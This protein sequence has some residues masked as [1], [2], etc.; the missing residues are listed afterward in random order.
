MSTEKRADATYTETAGSD[1]MP[2]R[3][4]PRGFGGKLKNHLRRFWWVHLITFVIGT[5]VIS[6]ILWVRS[7]QMSG[8]VPPY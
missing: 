1:G 4:P 3:T 2:G 6:I 8:F 7:S 5:I